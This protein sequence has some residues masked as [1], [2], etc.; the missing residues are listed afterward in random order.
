MDH[1]K[2][3]NVAIIAHVDHGKTTMVDE[4]FKQSDSM[5]AHHVIE[6]RM[7]DSIDQEKERGI[8]I[9]SKNGSCTYKDYFINIIDTPGHADFGGEVERVLKMADGVLFLVDAAEGPM[10]QSFFVL[11]KAVAL[12]LPVVVVVNKIDKETARIEWVI[13]QVFDLL[14]GLNAPDHI[15]DFKV[16]YASAKN[17]WAT[18]DYKVKTDNIKAI[19]EAIV[20][21]IPAPKGDVNGSFQMLVS[22][23]DYSPFMGRLAIGKITSGTVSVGSNLVAATPEFSSAS[24]RITKLYKFERN[25]HVEIE[26]ASVG[27]IIA[28]AGFKDVLVGQTAT[29]AQN[30]MPLPA[31]Q[32]DPPTISIRFL[33]NDSPLSGKEGEF[34]TS[35]Q[36]HDRLHREPLSDIAMQVEDDGLG[37]KV[38]GRGELHLSIFI[39]KLRREGYE[40]QVSRPEVIFKTVDGKKLEPYEV[41]TIDVSTQFIGKIIEAMGIRKGQM[42]DMREDGLMTRLIYKVPTRGILGYQAEFMMDTK[43]M[44]VMNSAFD[45]YGP[46]MGEIKLRQNGV[47]IAMEAGKT[48]AY[49][50]EGLEDRGT[51]ILGAGVQVYEGQIIGIH[52]RDNDLVVNACK[53]KKLTNMRASGSD[54]ATTLTP[55][56]QMTLEQCLSFITDDELIEITPQSIRVRKT[57]LSETERKRQRKS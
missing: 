38:S 41:V 30:P 8:T 19:F 52:S 42:V 50:L 49:A 51:L 24:V 6:E 53:G 45:E 35:R 34:V 36:L 27:E 16:V 37:F 55:H 15:L 25:K 46:Y 20:N 14:V 7:M 56:L 47:L 5:Q 43:G 9:K 39:E 40:F 21:Y 54:D 17:G 11:K 1:S 29:S 13:D 57:I 3:R 32:I 28:I 31:F 4:I 48:T 2:I 22:S 33:P 12:N 26:S 10:P 44:G 18:T 23:I